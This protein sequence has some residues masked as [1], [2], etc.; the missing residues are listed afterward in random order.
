VYDAA[1]CA[2]YGII[3]SAAC[4]NLVG[5]LQDPNMKCMPSHQAQPLAAALLFAMQR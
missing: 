4:D 2:A 1:C 5:R 3:H